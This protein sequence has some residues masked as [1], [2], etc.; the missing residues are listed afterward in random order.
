MLHKKITVVLFI[1]PFVVFTACKNNKQQQ[2]KPVLSYKYIETSADVATINND[3]PATLQGSRDIDIRPMI[4]G[5]IQSVYVDEGQT[6]NKGQLMFRIKNPQYEQTL[7][8]AQAALRSAKTQV[9]NARMQVTKVKPLVDKNIISAYE[10]EAAQL[11]LKSAQA[12]YAQAEAAVANASTNVGYTNIYAPVNGVVGTLPYRMGS[13]VNSATQQPLTTVSSIGEIYAYFSINE[14]DQIRFFKNTTGATV[15]EKL[16]NIPQVQLLL[17]DGTLYDHKGRV[18]SMSGL[19]ND[20]TGSFNLRATFPNPLGLLRSG[21]SATVRIPNV[22]Y[23][24][25]IVPQ[26]ATF[27]IQGKRF[28]YIIN[29]DSIVRQSPIE[30]TDMQ[31]GKRYIVN[32]GLST[33][34]KVVIEGV[35]ILKD[36]TLI[37]PQKTTLE[38]ALKSEI[39]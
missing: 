7:R 20:Q 29:K 11:Q 33:G 2:K 39:D 3:Y 30:V 4:D 25:V 15:Q 35:G 32:K 14:K 31:D 24:A 12:S 37:S 38:M 13:Y 8:S 22:V 16:K 28:V 36:S 19:V 27:E 9:D 18:Q 34:Q 1:L 6:V 23:D 17:A 26:A 21:N 10:L 5:Y